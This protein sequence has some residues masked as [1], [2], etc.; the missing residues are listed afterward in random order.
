[1]KNGPPASVVSRMESSANDP[2]LSDDDF[3]QASSLQVP[4]ELVE[5][6][7]IAMSR[8]QSDRYESAEELGKVLQKWLNGALNREKAIDIV[9]ETKALAVR[10]DHLKMEGERLL[11]EAKAGL[12]TIPKGAD[13]GIKGPHW[14]IEQE[15]L[16]KVQESQRLDLDIKYR[17][18]S[19]LSHKADLIE[20][21]E[22]LAQRYLQAHQD[23]EIKRD[24]AAIY[25]SEMRLRHHAL[26]L[27]EVNGF[28]QR[29]LHYLKGMGAVSLITD[30]EGVNITLDEYVPHH[31]RLIRNEWPIWEIKVSENTLLRWALTVWSY[32][33]RG[34]TMDL[35]CAH[36]SRGALGWS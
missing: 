35:S 16:A 20:A 18:Q 34:I 31:R 7:E 15:G 10:R 30:V 36:W 2:F 6:C 13:E 24:Q 33:K 22:A 26:A 11:A 5:A 32:R 1:M 17:L 23:A 19:A 9:K 25:Q 12:K 28:R 4:E 21:H 14:S 8:L 27:P 29:T 3:P